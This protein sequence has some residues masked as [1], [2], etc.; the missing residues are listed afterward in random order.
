MYSIK[1]AYNRHYNKILLE[2]ILKIEVI[3]LKIS[4]KLGL[5]KTQFELDFVDIDIEKDLPLFIDS[6]L[7]RK[8]DCEFNAKLSTTMDSFFS[9]LLNCL[10]NNLD[11]KAKY[12][13]SH[14]GEINETHLGLSKGLS[15][16]KGVGPINSVKIFEALKNSKAIEKGVLENIEDLR[17]LVNGVDKDL[18]SD[19][20]TNILKKHFLD[21]T[22]K[23]C[24]LH[25]V[26]LT[27]SVPSGFFWDDVACQWDNKYMKRL[28]I[29]NKPILLI[30]KKIVNYSLYGSFGEYKQHF[31]LNFLQDE[32]IRNCTNLVRKKKKTKELYVTKK[33]IIKTQP[34]MNKDYLSNFTM[35]HPEI[36]QKFKKENIKNSKSMSGNILDK[37]DIKDVCRILKESLLN[38]H[39]GAKMASDFHNLM[40]GIFELL[41]YPNLINPNKELE[42][43][44]G[45]KRIDICFN[46]VSE[47]GFFIYVQDKINIPCPLVFIE[48]KNYSS[49]VENPELDQLAG[50]F[51]TRRGRFGI[52][53]C[54]NIDNEK[55]FILRC[56]DTYRDDKKLIIPITD[57]DII[58]CL[59]KNENCTNEFEKI[60]FEKCTMIIKG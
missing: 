32:N 35:K 26:K 7:I 12:L 52:L 51:S 37:I 18:L 39:P 56:S 20:L 25:N 57:N 30:P 24:E 34:T 53:S 36:L 44:E 60:L 6:N 16:G 31:V 14:L 17:T 19:M 55:N 43:N 40:I 58:R 15:K 46:N 10:S 3:E 9:Y 49:D 50:R 23:Q 21:Y 41:L 11:E 13:C 2:Y 8:Y 42:I 5:N 27:E 4:E 1:I 33:D 59:E 47:Q 28:I 29:D 38:I 22:I 48:C 45:R 54:R